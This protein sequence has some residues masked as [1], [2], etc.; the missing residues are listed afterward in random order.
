MTFRTS[1]E[2]SED[3][4][5]RIQLSFQ[6]L[7]RRIFRRPFHCY[8]V[9]SVQS[10]LLIGCLHSCF[11][12]PFKGFPVFIRNIFQLFPTCCTIQKILC[13]GHR[14]IASLIQSASG[15]QGLLHRGFIQDIQPVFGTLI[16]TNLIVED[17]CLAI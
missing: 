13:F 4:R 3:R 8:P 1:V 17:S 9:K 6:R 7:W 16:I 12:N 11:L 15:E 5:Y 14:M 10:F 2:N